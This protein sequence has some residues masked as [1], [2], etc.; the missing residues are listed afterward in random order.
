VQNQQQEKEKKEEKTNNQ[1]QFYNI[2][3]GYLTRS[4]IKHWCFI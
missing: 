4:E 3:H 2:Q 1:K